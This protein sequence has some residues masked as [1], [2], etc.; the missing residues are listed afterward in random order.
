MEKHLRDLTIAREQRETEQ[1]QGAKEYATLLLKSHFA[2]DR[3]EFLT[4]DDIRS[5]YK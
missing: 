2:E 4:A 3:N 5:W 1:E